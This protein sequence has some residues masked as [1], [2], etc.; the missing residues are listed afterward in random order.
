M[1][2]EWNATSYHKVSAPQTSW[3]Q[4]VLAR[5]E[6]RGDERVIDA[7]C[8]S[9]RLTG[10]LLERRRAA[11]RVRRCHGDLHLGN[12]C[13]IDGRPTLFD[14][15]EFSDLIA[16]TDV[17]YDLAFLLMDLRHRALQRH[18]SQVFNRYVD[19]AADD[20]GVP[21][22]PLFMSLRAAVRAHVV[23]AAANSAETTNT[24]SL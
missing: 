6:L 16:C 17:L 2:R 23:S 8:G 18:C 10:D 1:S 15:I 5:L 24:T 9:G 7:G 12:I 13:L 22:L 4:K 11:S 20:D 21:A 19:L 14:C 3:G